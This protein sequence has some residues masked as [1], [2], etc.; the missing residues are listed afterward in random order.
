LALLR[1]EGFIAAQVERWLP[2]VNRRADVW[3][4]GDL[5]AANPSARVVLIVQATTADHVAARL[6]KARAR[7]ELAAWL[8]AGG[9]FEVHGW[10][11]RAGRWHVRRVTVQPEDLAAFEVQALPR[12]RRGRK[13]K[14]QRRLFDGEAF[15]EHGTGR[16]RSGADTER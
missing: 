2:A 5:L 1:R 11:L 12:G 3:G 14:P 6:A 15:R 8:R 4:F 13:A 16:P 10:C 9:A 7:P